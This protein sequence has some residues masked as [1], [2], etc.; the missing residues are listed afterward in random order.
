[1]LYLKRCV[2]AEHGYHEL[3]ASVVGHFENGGSA[4]GALGSDMNIFSR[5]T[6]IV[7]VYCHLSF[8]RLI[9]YLFVI[10]DIF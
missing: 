5:I 3:M 1:M 7:R 2:F 9:L 8:S 10:D 6:R 4:G